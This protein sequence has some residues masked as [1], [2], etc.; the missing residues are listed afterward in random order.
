MDSHAQSPGQVWTLFTDILHRVPA[1]RYSYM[2]DP[3][4]LAAIRARAGISEQTKRDSEKTTSL[5]QGVIKP[6]RRSMNVMLRV[7]RAPPYRSGRP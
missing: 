1:V 2:S 3:A 4:D 7:V 6:R 5:E